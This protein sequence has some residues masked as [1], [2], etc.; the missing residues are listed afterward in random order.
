MMSTLPNLLH[1]GNLMTMLSMS[2]ARK[3]REDA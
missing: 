3:E 1:I 2:K